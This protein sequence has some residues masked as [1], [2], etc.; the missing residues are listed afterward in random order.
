MSNDLKDHDGASGFIDAAIR[1][2][3]A[4]RTR[5]AE[6]RIEGSLRGQ[7]ARGLTEKLLARTTTGTI[8][9]VVIVSCIFAGRFT[10]AAIVTAMAWLCCSEFF[11]IAR[12]GGR[13][14][15]EV[16]GLT[17]AL[18]YP[19]VPLLPLEDGLLIVTFL[20]LV[21]C[22]C[23]YVA[24][25]RASLG[26]VA[27]TVF[28]PIYTSL[29]FSCVV[30]LRC[31]DP[32]FEGGLLTFGVMGSIW[33]ND[34]TAYFVGSRYGKRKLAPK[35]SPHKSVEGFWGGLIGCLFIWCIIAFIGIKDIELPAALA[36]GLL[37]GI[38]S[39]VGDLFESRLKRGV[40][41]KDSGTIMPGHGGL[42]DRSDSMLFGCTVAF[43]LLHF[44]GV[45]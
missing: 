19:L 18:I 11:H 22:A 13:M 42:L 8:Y 41:I 26:D 25:P 37:V 40:G 34:A 44:G 21:A 20:L 38:M 17:A 29:L 4:H 12:A 39:V 1:K 10:T 23:W 30:M 32:G 28:G 24:T 2:L 33:M 35:I 43:V 9:F 27:I 3:E 45:L 31:S 36:C 6:A 15:N 16:M 5:T 14:P 7:R